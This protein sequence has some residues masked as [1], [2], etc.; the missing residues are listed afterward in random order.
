[1]VR[2]VS[3]LTAGG[4]TSI[5]GALRG[6]GESASSAPSASAS[7]HCYSTEPFGL[8]TAT[9]AIQ[10]VL[11]ASGSHVG[12]LGFISDRPVRMDR[13]TCAAAGASSSYTCYTCAA[14]GASACKLPTGALACSSAHRRARGDW[15]SCARTPAVLRLGIEMTG[16]ARANRPQ[17]RHES[18][19]RG[20]RGANPACFRPS[21]VARAGCECS[22]LH[23]P[24][25]GAVAVRARRRRV[26][27]SCV[28]YSDRR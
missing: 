13:S 9:L 24:A 5:L 21:L 12:A 4:G 7:A 28:P 18:V 23:G 20:A 10:T 11:L 19:V 22:Q 6:G 27:S 14:A 17:K 15:V 16:S 1:M 26:H 25:R 2:L 8:G 3:S